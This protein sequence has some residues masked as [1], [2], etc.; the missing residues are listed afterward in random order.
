VARWPTTGGVLPSRLETGREGRS[1]HCGY[2]GISR[3]GRGGG[4]RSKG[5]GHAADT[6][7]EAKAAGPYRPHHGRH[8]L[9]ARSARPARPRHR[10]RQARIAGTR[11]WT[12]LLGGGPRPQSRTDV[13][14]S[15]PD[16]PERTRRRRVQAPPPGPL[17]PRTPRAVTCPLRSISPRVPADEVPASR[18]PELDPF[19]GRLPG[20]RRRQP[21]AGSRTSRGCP[22]GRSGRRRPSTSERELGQEFLT[23]GHQVLSGLGQHASMRG[24]SGP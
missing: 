24:N 10:A 19:P 1:S 7:R 12:P 6:G 18:R 15:E 23:V 21:G 8:V 4:H 16:R 22:R 11:R 20:A 5:C 13:S 3:S 17:P 2:K 9:A 14:P